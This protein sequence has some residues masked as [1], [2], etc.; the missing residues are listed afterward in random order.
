MEPRTIRLNLRVSPGAGRSAVVGRHGDAW[1]LRVAA[2]PGAWARQR[3]GGE[4][5]RDVARDRPA[6]RAHR[7]AERSR[8]TRSSRSSGSLSRRQSSALRLPRK[9]RHDDRSRRAP[10]GAA[11]PAGEHR[12][13]SRRPRG[14]RRGRG[15]DQHRRRRPAPR[16]SR[17]GPRRPRARSVARRERRQRGRRDRRGAARDSTPARTARCSVCG[18]AIPEE[19]LAAVPYATLCLDDKRRQEHG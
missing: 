15:G 1:K 14:G 13:R 11:P 3:V 16:R 9:E 7:R 4:P 19:R 10:G 18:A 5:A 12:P 8:A 17:L 6:G 2:A